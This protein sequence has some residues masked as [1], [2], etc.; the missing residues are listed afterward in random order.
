MK[1][2]IAGEQ[3]ATI[4]K[5]TRELAATAVTMASDV[6]QGTEPPVNDTTSYDNGVKV[7]PT[8]L[9]DPV[10][11]YKDNYQKVLIDSGLLH[12]RR[13]EVAHSP[14]EC[15]RRAH[16]SALHSHPAVPACR[17]PAQLHDSAR[18]GV[19]PWSTTTS[20]RCDRLPKNS[21]AS[22]PCRTSACRSAGRKSTPSAA[23]TAPASPP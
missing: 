15:G 8:K 9:L 19:A 18:D 14:A 6:L 21:R 20:W 3:F 2:I 16:A 13:P 11:V 4:F 17:G 7:V 1:S 5:D 12:R 10:V 23:R 22:R